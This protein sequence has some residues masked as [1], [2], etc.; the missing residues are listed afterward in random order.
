MW[1]LIIRGNNCSEDVLKISNLSI[2]NQ[3]FSRIY[4]HMF[5]LVYF[6]L[7]IKVFNF[8]IFLLTNFNIINHHMRYKIA[9]V[10]CTYS[11]D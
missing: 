1:M 2:M 3:L 5:I 11:S 8:Q 9:S 7:L 10:T 4:S 6:I